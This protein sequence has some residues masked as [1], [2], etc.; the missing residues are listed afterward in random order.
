MLNKTILDLNNMKGFFLERCRHDPESIKR[1]IKQNALESGWLIFATH[2]IDG[3]PTRFG[4]T[5]EMFKAIVGWAR[6]SGARILPVA[7]VLQEISTARFVNNKN[8]VTSVV[9]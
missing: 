9:S 8:S 5:P 2:D 3:K 6:E 7:A 4:L 1:I